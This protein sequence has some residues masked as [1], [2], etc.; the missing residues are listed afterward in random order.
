MSDK[1]V[2]YGTPFV[3]SEILMAIGNQD[4]EHARALLQGMTPSERRTLERQ[5]EEVAGLIQ[6]MREDE[7]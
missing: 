2:R 7:E 4:A 3:E 6:V 1:Q 5:C